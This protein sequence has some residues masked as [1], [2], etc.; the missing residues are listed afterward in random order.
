[1]LKDFLE[2]SSASLDELEDCVVSQNWS[3]S[4]S[5]GSQVYSILRICGSRAY[6]KKQLRTLE[7]NVKSESN[8]DQVPILLADAKAALQLLIEEIKTDFKF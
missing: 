1:M 4:Y 6:S 8:L 2:N 3:A 7:A 5:S